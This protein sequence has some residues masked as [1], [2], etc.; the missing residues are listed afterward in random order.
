VK[1]FYTFSKT[2]KRNKTIQMWKKL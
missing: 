2:V 1:I